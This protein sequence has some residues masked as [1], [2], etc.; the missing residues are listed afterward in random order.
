[1]LPLCQS[2]AASH[3]NYRLF[4]DLTVFSLQQY[5]MVESYMS[6]NNYVQ[7]FSSIKQ[8][9]FKTADTDKIVQYLFQ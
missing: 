4:G 7:F 8:Y 6:I 5:H 9:A 2:F 3:G 1:M